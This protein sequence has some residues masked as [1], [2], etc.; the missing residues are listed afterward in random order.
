[1]DDVFGGFWSSPE[2]VRPP[3]ANGTL[4]VALGNESAGGGPPLSSAT[5]IKDQ[6]DI[7]SP[8]LSSTH[9]HTY[10]VH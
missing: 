9:I 2:V 7:I 8:S 3:E 1:M 6:P 5:A 4:T 10:S